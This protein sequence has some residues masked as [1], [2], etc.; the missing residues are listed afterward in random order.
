MSNDGVDAL[1]VLKLHATIGP[2]FLSALAGTLLPYPR[3]AYSKARD[4]HLLIGQSFA[5][6]FRRVYALMADK[7]RPDAAAALVDVRQPLVVADIDELFR[8]IDWYVVPSCV[9]RWAVAAVGSD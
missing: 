8:K 9:V 6:L 5:V 4:R 1:W 3:T 2:A 7:S